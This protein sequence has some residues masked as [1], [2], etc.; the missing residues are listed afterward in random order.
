MSQ[1]LQRKLKAARE[2][3]EM[4]QAQFAKKIG[5]PVK[6]LQGWEIDKSTPRGLALKSINQILD[7]ILAAK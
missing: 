6:T 5:I 7:R 3:L 1:E 4:P 2:K